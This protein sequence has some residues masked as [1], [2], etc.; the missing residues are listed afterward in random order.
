MMKRLSIIILT[1]NQRETTFACLQS[2]RSFIAQPDV[3][4]IVVDNGSADGTVELLQ[5]H[6]PT[7]TLLINKK[8]RGVASA[9][10][11]GL[12]V[13]Q[14]E[15]ILILDNDTIAN[16][17]AIEG[18]LSYM[19]THPQTGLCACKLVD[20]TGQVQAS[21][22]AFPSV[23]IKMHNALN[24]NKHS[25]FTVVPINQPFEPTY[26]IGACQLIRKK[27]ADEVGM[28]DERIFYGPEDADYCLRIAKKGFKIIYLPQYT[29][30]HYWRRATTGKLFSRLAWKHFCGLCYFYIKYKRIH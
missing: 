18:M 16:D 19:A 14:G 29:I 7:L 10:N 12:R 26:V 6:F 8:N 23:W 30:I 9:R 3:E 27:V 11:K 28:L 1:W 13:A 17:E 5:N 25:S 20:E 22:K 2:L 15:Y 24:R 4:V 21:F